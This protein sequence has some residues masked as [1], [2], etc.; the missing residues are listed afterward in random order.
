MAGW[1]DSESKAA[2]GLSVRLEMV[3]LGWRRAA[4]AHV[5]ER[6]TEDLKV[7]GS[8]PVRRFVWAGG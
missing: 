1:L 2:C 4:I 6:R 8:I 3:G 7:T 5:G